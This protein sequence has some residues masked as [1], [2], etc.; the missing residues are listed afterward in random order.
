MLAVSSNT[1]PSSAEVAEVEA[2][3]C[4]LAV[5]LDTVAAN[6]RAIKLAVGS[7]TQVMAVVKADG[8]G[9]GAPAVAGAALRA[10]ASWLAVARIDEGVALRKAGIGAPI[11]NLACTLPEEA[12]LAVEYRI[13]PTV[14]DLATARALAAAAPPNARFPVHLKVDSGLSR[15][16]VQPDEL[17]PLLKNLELLDNLEIEGV[18]SHFATADE[19]DDRFA[20]QQLAR[21]LAT[22]RCLEARGLRLSLR[23]T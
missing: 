3:P 2:A 8:Y 22:L 14:V 17:L 18:F 13:R 1:A 21:F 11:L 7:S 19:A 15:F 6:V 16:G 9:L 20:R 4:W 5:D 10:G 23:H 12:E